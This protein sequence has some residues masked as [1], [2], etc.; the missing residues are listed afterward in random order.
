MTHPYTI[1]KNAI[2][3]AKTPDAAARVVDVKE[4]LANH[5]EHDTDDLMAAYEQAR[6]EGEIYS[7]P[8]DGAEIVK[9]TEDNL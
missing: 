9:V 5:D 1:I 2:S 3:R 4:V 8:D 7:Y 6:R